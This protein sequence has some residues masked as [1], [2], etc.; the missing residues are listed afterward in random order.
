MMSSMASC[1]YNGI[2]YFGGGKN[3][4]WSKITD[5]YSIDVSNKT[6]TKKANMLLARTSHQIIEVKGAIYV[7]GGFDDAGNGILSIESY[8]VQTNQWSLITSAPGSISK[9]WPQSLGFLNGKFYISAFLTPNTFKIMQKGYYYDVES[10]VWSE[11]PVINEKARYSPTCALAF[12]R[13][14]YKFDDSSLAINHNN[15]TKISSISN[16]SIYLDDRNLIDS[17]NE[18]S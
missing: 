8:N 6:M 12:P 2:I 15:R 13:Q 10:N 1:S 17:L 5:F 14:V 16:E 11:A 18:S 4:N 3:V 7:Y 9:T